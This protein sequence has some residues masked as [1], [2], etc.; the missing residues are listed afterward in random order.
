MSRDNIALKTGDM[1][2]RVFFGDLGKRE[3]ITILGGHLMIFHLRVRMRLVLK[4]LLTTG[5]FRLHTYASLNAIR[6]TTLS[7][8]NGDGKLTAPTH[9]H[10]R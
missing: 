6:A 10:H 4:P 8:M 3:Q 2:H 1:Q 5:L 9:H 7:L